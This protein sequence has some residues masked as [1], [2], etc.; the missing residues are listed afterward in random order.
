MIMLLSI[1]FLILTLSIW[2]IKKIDL[3][4]VAFIYVSLWV[5]SAL[6]FSYISGF[7][8]SLNAFMS[9]IVLIFFFTIPRFFISS[10]MSKIKI[11]VNDPRYFLISFNIIG[12]VGLCFHMAQFGFNF[13]IIE[14]TKM[15]SEARYDG[16][17]V[18]I[19]QVIS[20]SFLY[21]NCFIIGFVREQSL[22]NNFSN[23]ITLLLIIL[24]A[25]IT[26]S[27]ASMLF[28][29]SFYISG[30]FV[31]KMIINAN[32]SNRMKF[33]LAKKGLL[34]TF[35]VISLSMALQMLRYGSDISSLAYI[36]DK[37]IVYT[38][39]Q[40]S[41]YSIW[42]DNASLSE[43]TTI[44]FYSIFTGFFSKLF[45]LDRTAG[46]YD[47]FTYISPDAYTNVFTL[48][49]FLISDFTFFGACILL[50]FLGVIYAVSTRVKGYIYLKVV[51]YTAFSIEMLFGFSTSILSYN[52]VLLTLLLIY[53]FCK[54]KLSSQ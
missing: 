26:S 28:S 18:S 37:I 45:F 21:A 40:F 1:L 46:F 41:A 39:G 48:S 44:P 52:N 19:W 4:Y 51:L 6:I 54:V 13:K 16:S 5:F 33:G 20:S 42:F 9:H 14:L 30:L 10:N 12:A 23:L 34:I 25:V 24:S 8:I 22:K 17:G 47:S 3:A 2:K 27:K 35:S 29:L 50:F 43:L 7:Y 53:I 36:F 11:I 38:F 15:A 32:L 31:F 49:R